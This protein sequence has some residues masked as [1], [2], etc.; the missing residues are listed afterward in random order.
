[1]RGLN[2]SDFKFS[3]FIEASPKI[4]DFIDLLEN[5]NSANDDG[6]EYARY[7][8]S[9][10][11][12]KSKSVNAFGPDSKTA[13][14]NLFDFYQL[15]DFAFKEKRNI[16]LAARIFNLSTDKLK[17]LVYDGGTVNKSGRLIRAVTYPLYFTYTTMIL[18]Y[19]NEMGKGNKTVTNGNIISASFSIKE[20]YR[21]LDSKPVFNL[22]NPNLD[23]QIKSQVN[24]NTVILNS[25]KNLVV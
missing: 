6:L 23:T 7:S 14:R 3:T 12:Y 22:N 5:L 13:A 18:I 21:R 20:L 19:M 17:P 8:V 10:M 1:M 15:K 25:I 11:I 4:Q 16:L 9:S 2:L 24:K